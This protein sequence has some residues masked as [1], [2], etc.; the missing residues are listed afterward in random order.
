MAA[1]SLAEL[2]GRVTVLR[3]TAL[4]RALQTTMRDKTSDRRTFVTKS[5]RLV[6]Y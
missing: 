2:S 6:T 3:E 4:T 5:D 1:S